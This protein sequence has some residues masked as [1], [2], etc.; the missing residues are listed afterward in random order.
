[1]GHKGAASC[2]D[3]FSDGTKLVTGGL[4]HFVR[5][6]DVAGE[7]EIQKF[8]LQHEVFSVGVSPF[9]PWIAVG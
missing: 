1:M 8:P 4:D 9:E 5:V 6:W 2:I 7:G 3:I